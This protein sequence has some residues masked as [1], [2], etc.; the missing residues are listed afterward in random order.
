MYLGHEAL[1]IVKKSKNKLHDY[2]KK[3]LSTAFLNLSPTFLMHRFK[4][5]FFQTTLR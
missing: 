1:T 5:V 3:I 4:L 2:S